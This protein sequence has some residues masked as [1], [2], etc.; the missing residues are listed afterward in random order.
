MIVSNKKNLENTDF[1]EYDI[2]I[3]IPSMYNYLMQINT[4]KAWKRFIYDEPGHLRVSGM[5]KVIAGFYWLI[6]AT[7]NEIITQHKNC[8]ESFMKKI[9]V[10]DCFIPIEEQFEGMIVKNDDEF[11]KLSFNMPQT[12]E[13]IHNCYQPIFKTLSGFV[14]SHLHKLIES[15][16][17]EGAINHLGGKSKNLIELVKENKL[18]K[19]EKLKGLEYMYEHIDINEEKLKKTQQEITEINNDITEIEKRT[20]SMLNEKCSICMQKFVKPVLETHCQNIFCGKCFLKWLEKSKS[21]PL[22]RAEVLQHELIYLSNK[23]DLVTDNLN[24]EEDQQKIT[25]LEMTVKIIN[26]NENGKYIIYSSNDLCFE[27]LCR[28]LKEN[29]INFTTLKGN[30]K[31]REKCIENFKY[32]N[33]NVILLNT[34]YNGS[35]LNLQEATD[36]IMY[37]TMSDGIKSQIIG[38]ANRIGRLKPLNVHY[39]KVNL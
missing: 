22:C 7:P 21:C 23:T 8:R 38:R 27:P 5:K 12:L 18:Q 4:N 32:G 20:I 31:T 16:N 15:G 19:L 10:D 36:I 26:N 2:V 24:N 37:H 29:N 17:I 34:N 39:L 33:T 30:Y 13:F 25:Q 3:V 1:N 35:G 9:L 11:V 28:I 6:T 14:D